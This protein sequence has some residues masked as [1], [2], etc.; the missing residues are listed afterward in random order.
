MNF[1]DDID[2][3]FLQLNREDFLDSEY[4]RF[5]DDDAPLQLANDGKMLVPVGEREM[6]ELIRITKDANGNT[7]EDIISAVRF[8]ELVGKYGWR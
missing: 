8:V 7:R 6:Q 5:A 1:L 2:A 4:R 3:F